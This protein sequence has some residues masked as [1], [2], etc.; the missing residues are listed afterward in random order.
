MRSDLVLNT[1]QERRMRYWRCNRGKIA[2]YTADQSIL[3]FH[4]ILDRGVSVV[5]RRQTKIRDRETSRV[6]L[7]KVCFNLSACNRSS[8]KVFNFL[9][10]GADADV[11]VCRTSN[12]GRF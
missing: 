5:S 7:I 3:N 9:M 1:Y 2:G 12:S 10:A 11:P 4:D 6:S 8:F